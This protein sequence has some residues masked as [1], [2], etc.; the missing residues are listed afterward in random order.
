LN[1]PTERTKIINSALSTLL[2]NGDYTYT[3]ITVY[4]R[5]TGAV[6]ATVRPILEKNSEADFTD[7]EFEGIEDG[8]ID[9]A[10][11]PRKRTFTIDLKRCSAVRF[12]D[13]GAGAFT[14]HIRQWGRANS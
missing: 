2:L 7:D 9:L 13:G 1:I 6:T 4:G 14:V 12:E 3:Q 11:T 5:N 8:A 10:A